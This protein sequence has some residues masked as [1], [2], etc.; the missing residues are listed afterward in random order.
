[1]AATTVDLFAF[2]NAAGPQRPRVNREMFPDTAGMIDPQT[3]PPWHGPSTL[4]NL[5]FAL[6]KGHDYKLPAG[7]LLPDGLDVV[8]DGSDVQQASPEPPS[9]HTFF[10]TRPM[11]ADEFVEL[12]MNLPWRHEGKRP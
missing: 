4:G 8:A 7:T 5:S 10:P 9:H 6:L 3:G 1:M 11:T 2:G 12:Y